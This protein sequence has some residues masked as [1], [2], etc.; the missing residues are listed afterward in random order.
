MGGIG[1]RRKNGRAVSSYDEKTAEERAGEM[2][3]V[4]K[5]LYATARRLPGGFFVVGVTRGA[6][7]M[8]PLATTP[9]GTLSGP[10]RG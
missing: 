4:F 1:E 2:V 3:D 8:W 6:G 9:G 7:E 10:N 5:E